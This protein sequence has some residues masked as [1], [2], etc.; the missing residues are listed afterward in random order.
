MRPLRCAL[1]AA[2]LLAAAGAGAGELRDPSCGVMTVATVAGQHRYRLPHSFLRAGS[3]SVW[4]RRATWVRGTDY[5]LDA[6]RGDVRILTDVAPGETL[7]VA[8]CWLLA[9]P[10]LDYARQRYQ[11]APAAPAP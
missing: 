5:V 8:A 9:P 10:P 4:T 6:L 1:A 7:W 3:D 2:A 11:A